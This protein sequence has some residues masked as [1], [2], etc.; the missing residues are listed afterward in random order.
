MKEQQ[1]ELVRLRDFLEKENALEA[2]KRE[3]KRGSRYLESTLDGNTMGSIGLAMTWRGTKEGYGFWQDL[4]N[5]YNLCYS[6]VTPDE[7][8]IF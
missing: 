7:Y 1:K 2:F 8:E 6:T 4:S 3:C 5:K